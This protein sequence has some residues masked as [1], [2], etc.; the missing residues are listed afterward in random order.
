[1]FPIITN[2]VGGLTNTP[3][4]RLKTMTLTYEDGS[5]MI[6]SGPSADAVFL[7]MNMLLRI[8]MQALMVQNARREEEE[9]VDENSPTFLGSNFREHVQKLENKES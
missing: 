7:E 1:M 3:H 5:T 9:E 4:N 6:L 8:A 2:V